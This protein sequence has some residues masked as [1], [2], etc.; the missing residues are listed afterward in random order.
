MLNS[1]GLLHALQLV[2]VTLEARELHLPTILQHLSPLSPPAVLHG[3]DAATFV[4]IVRWLQHGAAR[5]LLDDGLLSGAS[6]LR[7]GALSFASFASFWRHHQRSHLPRDARPQPRRPSED[8]RVDD[9][10]PSDVSNLLLALGAA[11]PSS[12]NRH[13]RASASASAAASASASRGSEHRGGGF[14]RGGSD[15]AEAER[16]GGALFEAVAQGQGW[17]SGVALCE[18]LCSAELNEAFDGAQDRVC[19]PNLNVPPNQP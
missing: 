4:R 16:A 17:L 9:P 5:R 19:R 2:G 15:E 7:H 6:T 14:G 1:T 10:S 12:P 3:V 18:A 8:V 11:R 13:E